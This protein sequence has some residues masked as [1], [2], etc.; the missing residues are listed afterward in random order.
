[1]KR[2]LTAGFNPHPLY[3][4]ARAQMARRSRIAAE[5]VGGTL[6]GNWTELGPTDAGGRMRAILIDP[7][8]PQ[9]MY[10]AAVSGGVFKSVNAGK[11]W[12]DTGDAMANLDVSSL[13][14]DP[15]DTRVIY[16]GTGEGYYREDVR[17]TALVIRGNGIF[18]SRDAGATWFQLSSTAGDD[19][20]FVNDLAVSPH[21]HLRMYAATRTGVWRS[22]DRGDSWTNVLPTTV[23]GG[24]LDLALRS[25]TDGDFLF[26]SCGTFEQATVYRNRNAESAAAWESVLTD[27]NMGRTS[28]A[29]APSN[30]NII[31]ALAAS[32]APGDYYQGL[33]AVF[34]SDQGGDPG[35]W[36]ERIRT[37]TATDYVSTLLLTNP[38]AALSPQCHT[39]GRDMSNLGWHGNVIAVDPTNP[40]N[41][42][43]GGIDLF[44]SH[45][46]GRTWQPV[47][48]WWVSPSAN[49]YVHADL[50]AIVFPPGFGE[51][52][53]AMYIGTDGGI[54]ETDNAVAAPAQPMN[55]VTIVC[56]GA[57]DLIFHTYNHGNASIQFYSGAATPDGS[58]YLGGA[59]D[60]GTIAGDAVSWQSIFGGDG[61]YVAID[62]S[63]P[64]TWYV[65]YQY[66]NLARRLSD[67][68][69]RGAASGLSDDFV[70]VTPFTLNPNQPAQLW[71]GGRYLWRSSDHGQS[72][73]RLTD[74]GQ[75][76]GQLSA[77]AIARGNA[78]NIVA[79]TTT[80]A[81]YR[82][83]ATGT[84]SGAWPSTT[85]RPGFVSSLT[86]VDDR[87]VYATY[88]LFGGGPHLW[89]STDAGATWSAIGLD[90]PDLPLHAV[91]A[92]GSRLFLGTDLGVFVS[93]DNGATWTADPAFP[94]VI[95]EAVFV[96][97]DTTGPALYAFTHGRGA[98]R[99]SLGGPPKRRAVGR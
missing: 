75:L 65:E 8:D 48:A 76:N 57:A 79:A 16:A 10:A 61:G 7:H 6:I 29:I 83:T 20:D 1:M 33:L 18:V 53:H 51:S 54:Y 26:A 71:T 43:A 13:A 91:A 89:R 59:Q 31:Y 90:L 36:S 63:D 96:G 64:G 25:D 24:C 32:N 60:N 47:S 17:G 55:S 52:N 67:G 49:S 72:W 81:I 82:N 30:P 37:D 66:A 38:I 97:R 21:D 2:G 88:A 84:P 56:R 22:A 11:V 68:T 50:H 46:G 3:D 92:Y 41:V 69:V 40:D 74:A 85:P 94:A 34:R 87:T 99:A 4:A 44:R 86:F 78:G 70:F 14:F 35:S 98:W 15:D 23:K 12:T 95:T 5:A 77:I 93:T 80:G 27:P 9:V 45:D 28:L 62:P 73:T 19:F 39:G 58:Q 42:W